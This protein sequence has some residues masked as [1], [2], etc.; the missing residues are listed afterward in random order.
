MCLNG[1][2]RSYI[3][4]NKKKWACVGLAW[5][6]ECSPMAQETWVQSLV[7]SCQRLK[8]W[9]LMLPF[10]TLSIIRYGSRVKWSNPAKGVAPFPTP[11][12][13]SYQKRRLQV[14]LDKS[15]QLYFYCVESCPHIYL[16]Y[17][18]SS[19]PS[20]NRKP[21]LRAVCIYPTSLQ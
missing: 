10:L 2:S 4:T 11:Q 19:D 7:E 8:K 14:T 9:F 15:C 12:C 3:K 17:F 6:L 20:I 21:G 16:I 13:S 18:F 5:W 1:W